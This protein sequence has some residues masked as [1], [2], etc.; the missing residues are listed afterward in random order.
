[1]AHEMTELD[2][3]FS[4]NRI[5]PWHYGQGTNV[6]LLDDAPE[7][8]MQRMVAAGHDWTVIEHD[9]MDAETFDMIES[10]KRLIRSDTGTELKVVNKSYTVIQNVVGHE[11]FEALIASHKLT[12]ATGGTTNGGAVCYLQG[13]IDEP[14]F[15]VGDDSPIYPYTGVLWS[16]D[17][18]TSF[19]ALEGTI[20][21]V[22]K[23]TCKWAEL[24]AKRSGHRYVFK[25]TANALEKIEECKAVISGVSQ[26]TDEL[27]AVLNSL[28]LLQA[29]ARQR[30]Q[31][32]KAVIPEPPAL[33]TTDRV[34][35]NIEKARFD[36]AALF[37]TETIPEAHKH[38]GYGLLQAGI[39]YLDH[40]RAYQSIATYIGRTLLN[41]EPLKKRLVPIIK[42]VCAA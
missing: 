8:R 23:N 34:K 5:L 29:G 2:Q 19:Q 35:R 38:T 41:V 16:H 21:M 18:S 20:R 36:L 10:S 4:A 14:R 15:V 30:E 32:I 11:I 7:T 31:F 13:Q 17:L 37:D 39:E 24:M 42:E 12:D 27:I 33:Y 28:G 3:M 1:M 26:N 40:V 22:C 6:L 9:I 25:H